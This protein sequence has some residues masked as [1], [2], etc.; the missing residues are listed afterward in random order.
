MAP[1][2]KIGR[3][4]TTQHAGIN[5]KI[6]NDNQIDALINEIES[7][8]KVIAAKDDVINDLA[9]ERNQIKADKD[10][11][12]IKYECTHEFLAEKIKKIEELETECTKLKKE[13]DNLND[14]VISSLI[15][16]R[17]EIL[18]LRR[19]ETK[20][21]SGK[22][23]QLEEERKSLKKQF[24]LKGDQEI[25]TAERGQACETM[26]C[27]KTVGEKSYCA[28][29]KGS[30]ESN[31]AQN[32]L[33]KDDS[34]MKT[35][36]TA[37]LVDS[38]IDVHSLTKLIDDRI[39]VTI[40][41]KLKE[42]AAS[43]AEPSRNYPSNEEFVKVMYTNGDGSVEQQTVPDQREH[44]IIIH[45]MK[46]DSTGEETDQM[47][48][49]ELFD[50]V[51]LNYRTSSVDRLGSKIHQKARP[52]RIFM[53]SQ[54]RKS[55]FMSKLGRLRHGPEKFQKISITD[56]YTQEERKEIRRWV[57][58]ARKRTKEEDGYAWKVRGSPRSMLRLI[59]IRT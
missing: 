17:E 32:G 16:E 11:L 58:E 10:A 55:E 9:S 46:E 14:D 41:N 4:E 20:E 44:N 24:S 34:G 42:H 57:E 56:D 37:T 30:D 6:G 22:I 3:K 2:K 1:E 43:K 23:K 7:L 38:G 48:I 59:K 25:K 29:L 15:H 33:S 40:D 19:R 36:D 35:S 52:I 21:L 45:G 51:G 27:R 26:E 5:E 53:E 8:K 28:I 13:I 49:E 18:Q 50:T 39:S 54:T 47:I 12:D 31:T